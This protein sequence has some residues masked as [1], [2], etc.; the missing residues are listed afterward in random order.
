MRRLPPLLA[1]ATA[2]LQIAIASRWPGRSEHLTALALGWG[3][4]LWLTWIDRDPRAYRGSPPLERVLGGA[5]LAAT[6][7]A[8]LAGRGGYA[9]VNRFLPVLAGLGLLLMAAG[10]HRLWVHR[11]QLL[12]LSLTLLYPLPYAIQRALMPTELTA[13][14]AAGLVRVLGVPV[15]RAGTTL[16]FP[17]A[18]LRVLDLCSGINLM[19]QMIML[20]VVVLCF[21]PTSP[22]RAAMVLCIALAAGFAVNA[23]RIALL[24]VVVSRAP[25][26]FDYWEQYVAGSVLFPVLATALAGLLWKVVLRR[27]AVPAAT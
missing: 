21:F 24:G 5:I 7:L 10:V 25:T 27:G 23:A 9:L 14:T 17:H 11:G 3:G 26:D 1:V 4:A 12:L 15:R 20:A 18:T 2:S 16:V 19:T 8:T 13:A 22:R 6:W